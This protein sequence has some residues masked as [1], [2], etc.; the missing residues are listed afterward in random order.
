MDDIDTRA[1]AV[2]ADGS[3]D[4]SPTL[5]LSLGG[6]YTSDQRKAKILR[7]IYFGAAGT[8]GLGTPNALLFRTDTNYTNGELDK[9]DTKFTPRVSVEWKAMPDQNVYASYSQ[10]FKGGGFD[11][12][13]NVVGTRITDAQARAGFAPETINTYE[14]GLK[15]AFAGQRF[16]SNLAVFYSD[17][18]SVQIPGSLAIDTN[19]DGKD[20][21]FA[22]ITTNAGKAKIKGV[23]LEASARVTNAFTVSG[24][25]SY[26]DAKYDQY[27]VNGVN[28]ASARN[29]QNTPRNSSHLRANYDLHVP[30]MGHDGTLSLLASAAFKGKTYQFET[31]SLLDQDAY[32]V[33]DASVVWTRRDG[34]IRAG[35][36]GRNLS[37]THYKTAGYLYPTL[38]FEGVVTAFYGPP[39]TIAASVEY[40]F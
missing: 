39:R 26:I 27:I 15:S 37:N 20:D 33:Y 32:Y 38:G 2:Y 14:L 10:G 29:F 7:Q 30:M 24:M 28:V 18:K 22:G 3:M 17:Y 21:S 31:P 9:T 8:P 6:R 40:R 11:P 1:W 36:Y 35:I 25:Y 19:G 13:L 5:S 34:K 16:L 23:E 4:I 12:R